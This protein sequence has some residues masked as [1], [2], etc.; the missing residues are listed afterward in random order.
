[1]LDHRAVG[2][3]TA[4]C[5]FTATVRRL[6]E[7]M[8]DDSVYADLDRRLAATDADLARLYPGE[9][10]GRQPVHTVYVPADRFH[11]G[12][13]PEWGRLALAALADFPPLPFDDSLAGA[14]RAKLARE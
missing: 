5:L 9:P 3:L 13:A 7:R 1:M 14:V 12:L 2:E 8:L 4:V 11:A 6:L 10:P